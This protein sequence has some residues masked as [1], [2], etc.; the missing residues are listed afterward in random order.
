ME[1]NVLNV[2]QVPRTG[3]NYDGKTKFRYGGHDLQELP[4]TN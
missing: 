2:Q 1:L 4:T 3:D